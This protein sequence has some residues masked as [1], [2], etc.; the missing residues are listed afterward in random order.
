MTSQILVS[1]EDKKEPLAEWLSAL[2]EIPLENI[3]GIDELGK[4]PYPEGLFEKLTETNLHRPIRVSEEIDGVLKSVVYSSKQVRLDAF[5]VTKDFGDYGDVSLEDYRDAEYYANNLQSRLYDESSIEFLSQ[6]NLALHAEGPLRKRDEQ[7]ENGW[8]RKQIQE[9]VFGYIQQ[10]AEDQYELESLENIK[11]VS[12][13]SCPEGSSP[14]CSPQEVTFTVSYVTSVNEKTGVVNLDQDYT[15][16]DTE[17]GK[18]VEAQA[19]LPD[20][21]QV[22]NE[23]AQ[24]ALD[25]K[26]SDLCI[27]T[28]ENIVYV[29]LNNTNASLADW[30]A[31]TFPASQLETWVVKDDELPLNAVLAESDLSQNIEYQNLAIAKTLTIEEDVAPVGAWFYVARDAGS[32]GDV[33]ILKG[34]NV[35]FQGPSGDV[36][37][38]LDASF[39]MYWIHRGGNVWIYSGPY[40]NV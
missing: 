2:A 31:I 36:D 6:S 1:F 4:L 13:I 25:V 35:V 34:A 22:A 19:L 16:L 18:I 8:L 26:P 37:I 29:A 27:R 5:C 14:D 39:S 21:F 9:L 33:D 28:D 38:R 23:S 15:R 30:V 17:T 12:Y 20:V 7:R 32:T 10:T 3:G 40:Q 11:S 24:L